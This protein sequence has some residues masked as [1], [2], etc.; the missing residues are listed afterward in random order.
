MVTRKAIAAAFETIIP[1]KEMKS[2]T[3]FCSA[4]NISLLKTQRVRVTRVAKSSNNYRVT[5]GRM[6]YA[7]REYAKREAEMKRLP[8]I[9]ASFLPKKKA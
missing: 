1:N 5:L 9:M 7:E 2:I 8:R 6:N 4:K 3:I